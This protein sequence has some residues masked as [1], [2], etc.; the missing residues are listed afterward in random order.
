[1]RP[2]YNRMDMAQY[3]IMGPETREISWEPTRIEQELA[4]L[5]LIELERDP[6]T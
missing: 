1:M 6:D 5:G 2:D 3:I 4:R